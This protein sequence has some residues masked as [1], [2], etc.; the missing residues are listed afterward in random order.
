MHPPLAEEKHDLVAEAEGALKSA[1]ERAGSAAAG[2]MIDSAA[3]QRIVT[4]QRGIPL[5]VLRSDRS[6]EQY[7]A[8]S[9]VVVNTVP[10][11]VAEEGRQAAGGTASAG[12]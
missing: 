10:V 12:R 2:A 1:L 8:A 9:R 7:L 3:V 4:E 11:A 5:P 6:L